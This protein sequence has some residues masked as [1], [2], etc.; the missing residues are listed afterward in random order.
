M[1]RWLLLIAL[2]APTAATAQSAYPNFT[3]GSMTSTTTTDTTITE[4]IAIERYGGNYNSWSGTNVT[5]SGAVGDANTTYS[6][7]TAGEDF[8]VEVVSRT[9]GVM[10]TED[11]SRTIEQTSVTTSL[12]VFS[13]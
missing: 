5:A 3:Q 13:Q 11:I 12:S 10:E 1:K 9:A 7:H 8:Q 2:A 4:T 6:I